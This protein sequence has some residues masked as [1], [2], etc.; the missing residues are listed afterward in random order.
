M[1]SIKI[2]IKELFKFGYENDANYLQSELETKYDDEGEYYMEVGIA[3]KQIYLL[4]KRNNDFDSLEATFLNCE[5]A[6]QKIIP[7]YI[8]N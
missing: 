2:L 3:V 7:Q 4:Q 8:I 5:S 1:K 6:I